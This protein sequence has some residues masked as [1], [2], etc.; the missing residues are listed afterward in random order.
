MDGL[1][2]TQ[3]ISAEM[4]MGPLHTQ[5]HKKQWPFQP[6]A[7]QTLIKITFHT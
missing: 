2:C 3:N 7:K 4:N 6:T 1:S 5:K